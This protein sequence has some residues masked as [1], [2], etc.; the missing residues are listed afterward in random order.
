MPK[1][2]TRSNG[3]GSRR[4]R[5]GSSQSS[6]G[7]VVF[8]GRILTDQT[9]VAN[10]SLQF[11]SLQLINAS[12][13]LVG[14]ADNFSF[15]Q[16]QK[17]KLKCHPIGTATTSVV[18][19][20]YC[21]GPLAGAP[22]NIFE[23]EFYSM[24]RVIG[25]NET[26]CTMMPIPRRLLLS[27]TPTRLFRTATTAGVAEPVDS[28]QF[29]I[30]VLSNAAVTGFVMEHFFTIRF[31]GSGPAGFVPKRKAPLSIGS[32]IQDIEELPIKTAPCTCCIG[33]A[34]VDSVRAPK[35]L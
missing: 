32:P 20:A 16:V 35:P 9:L 5:G 12:S 7:E 21:P 17:Y 30:N 4:G 18:T 31:T 6:A 3:R 2:S 29:T 19:V 27:D 26:V 22:V 28:T 8:S 10:T 15:Y 33:K 13:T 25:G 24:S 23:N 14:L 34:P 11:T 1:R